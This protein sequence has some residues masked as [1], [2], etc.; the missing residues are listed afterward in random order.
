SSSG[1]KLVKKGLLSVNGVTPTR[2]S[3]AIITELCNKESG[4]ATL[5]WAPKR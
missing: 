2:V 1:M 4:N 3:S 5:M